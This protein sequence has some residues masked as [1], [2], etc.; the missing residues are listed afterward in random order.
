M[1]KQQRTRKVDKHTQ[2]AT[3]RHS[4]SHAMAAV[5]QQMFPSAK[6]GIGPATAE[7]FYYDF[8]LPR[9]LTPEDLPAIETKMREL[10]DADSP[11][12]K[13]ISGI[14]QA[15]INAEQA[16][17]NY[18]AELMR[19]LKTKGETQV[20]FYKSGEFI[21]LCEGPHVKSTKKIGAVK[22][23]SVAGA[24][25]RGDEKN[26]QLTRIY[27][28]AFATADEL[29]AYLIRL[30]E[31]KKRDH[32]LIGEQLDW[33]SFHPEGPGFVFW[34]SK[35]KFI[36][37][38]I[39]RYMRELLQQHHYQEIST[40]I[41]LN[42]VL[43]HQSGHWDNYK[44]AMYFTQID[45]QKYAIKPMNCPGSLLIFK[46]SLR[47]YRDLPMR[48]SEFGLV[49]R[50]EL[51][52]V[53]HGLF[54]VRAFTQDDAHI[55]CTPGQIKKEIRQLIQLTRGVYKTFGFKKYHIELSTRPAKS[56]GSDA[57]WEKSE[58]IMHEITA[59]EKLK[60]KI[61]EGEGAFY[62]PKFD[63]HIEDALGRTWQLATIQLDF[64][65][66]ER[67]GAYY[68]DQDGQKKTPV[69]IHRTIIGSLERFIGILIE[70]YAG[71][72]PMW[73]APLQ[74]IIL[75]IGKAQLTYAQQVADQLTKV[76][77]RVGLDDRNESLDRK[78]RDAKLQK[79]PYIL[80]VG[81]QEQQNQ[82]VSIREI[83]T[84]A[85][86]TETLATTVKKLRRFK[87]PIKKI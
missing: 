64:S 17:Q 46:N 61:N 22:L 72:F 82:T 73:L 50:H 1:T 4:A 58:K 87:S 81:E 69:M 85:Q 65:M 33:F 30:E 51:S 40:P 38:Q 10:I 83:T 45:E 29:A 41:I 3:L 18:K 79:I 34:H 54:R 14:D 52:G 57:I 55:Y 6:F 26:P 76:K 27:G 37:D 11:I 86:A 56:I 74:A 5:I 80:V 43:W 77:L 24:Y 63:F 7:G 59:E 19:D 66:A 32:R 78:I 39:L 16:G 47:S 44:D 35:G 62:G 60:V 13:S 15:I 71:V 25:W 53:L 67:L 84:D 23:L 28:T 12:T 42:E 36:A 8:E 75:P 31:A 21:D 68:I 48:V 2:L 20:T 70:H 49:H 9:P